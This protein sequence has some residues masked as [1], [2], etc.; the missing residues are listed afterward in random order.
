MHIHNGPDK[1][2][3]ITVSI[4]LMNVHCLH[5]L[6]VPTAN[7]TRKF[8]SPYETS[9]SFE[10]KGN[11]DEYIMLQDATISVTDISKS[12]TSVVC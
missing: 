2:T 7:Q 1:V 12:D 5:C 3:C 9:S 10:T 4:S 8:R 6:F 11:D